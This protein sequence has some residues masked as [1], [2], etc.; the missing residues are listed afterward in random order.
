VYLLLLVVALIVDGTLYPWHF[1]L[2]RSLVGT[3]AGILVAQHLRSSLETLVGAI[4]RWWHQPEWEM[5][6]QELRRRLCGWT[7]QAGLP[8]PVKALEVVTRRL[9]QVYPVYRKVED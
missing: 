1:D 8:T 4:S 6:D 5:S 9:R 2:R 3:V 7:A